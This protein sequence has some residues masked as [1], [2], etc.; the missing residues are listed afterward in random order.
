[1]RVVDAEPRL[2]VQERRGARRQVP[3]AT[4]STPSR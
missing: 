1:M 2:E 3:E 4:S